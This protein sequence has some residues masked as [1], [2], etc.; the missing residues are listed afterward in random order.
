MRVLR[1]KFSTPMIYILDGCA[2]V[3]GTEYPS[4]F[5]RVILRFLARGLNADTGQERNEF[6]T[7]TH[8]LFYRIQCKAS[9]GEHTRLV[10]D[11]YVD[12]ADRV[13]AYS[14]KTR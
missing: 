1:I 11:N 6:I 8:I 12:H 14:D 2:T 4:V 5:G 7:T 9:V 10:V 13:T 3:F